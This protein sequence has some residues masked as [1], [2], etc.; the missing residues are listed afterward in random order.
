MVWHTYLL[1]PGYGLLHKLASDAESAIYSWYTEDIFRVQLLKGLK[2]IRSKFLDMAVRSTIDNVVNLSAYPI[3]QQIYGNIETYVPTPPRAA[4]WESQ[5]SVPFDP[6]D[7]ATQLKQRLVTCPQCR[8]GTQTGRYSSEFNPKLPA[9]IFLKDFI[10]IQGTG[11]AQQGFEV[12]CSECAFLITRDSL[13]VYRFLTNL[14]DGDA[15]N[16]SWLA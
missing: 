15:Q 12:P 2:P 5:T 11:Y 3:L 7:S 9:D 10:N 16:Y 4:L 8:A 13:G 14:A 6:F 1:N